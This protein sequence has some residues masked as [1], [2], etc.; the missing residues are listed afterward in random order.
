MLQLSTGEK[1]DLRARAHNLNPVVSIAENGLTESVLKEIDVNLKAHELI[2][3]RVY[4]DSR[5][6]REAYLARICEELGA[7]A[8]QHIGK[9]LIVFR[10]AP[11]ENPAVDAP[12]SQ[13]NQRPVATPRRSKRSFQG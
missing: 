11:I 12:K 8:V 7:A 10:P 9:L 13:K 3:I 2:K 5:D 1:R 4:G 6:D